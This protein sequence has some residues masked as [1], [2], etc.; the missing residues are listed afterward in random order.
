[1][2]AESEAYRERQNTIYLWQQH[3]DAL[4]YLH[5]EADK[6]LRHVQPVIELARVRGLMQR[7]EDLAETQMKVSSS[8]QAVKEILASCR[9][10]PREVPAGQ[11]PWNYD[12]AQG[13]A[14][15]DVVDWN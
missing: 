8:L 9:Q 1:M 15:L 6:G 5:D 11:A 10:R 4:D 3:V 2:V 14:S 13:Q 7:V 12:G